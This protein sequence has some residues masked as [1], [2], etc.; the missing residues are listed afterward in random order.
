[1]AAIDF[2]YILDA[3]IGITVSVKIDAVK[4]HIPD[5]ARVAVQPGAF[6]EERHFAGS[7]EVGFRFDLVVG[8]GQDRVAERRTAVIAIRF[9]GVLLAL[10]DSARVT[11]E[12]TAATAYIMDNWPDAAAAHKEVTGPFS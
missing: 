9:G 11:D 1:M 3:Y 8:G 2:I 7:D 10:G 6:E 5:V 4:T 12:G